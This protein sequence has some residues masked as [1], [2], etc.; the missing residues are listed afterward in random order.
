MRHE[1]FNCPIDM[2]TKAET[3]SLVREAMRVRKPMTHVS[4]N[5]AK[6]VNMRFDP[7]LAEGREEQRFDRN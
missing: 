2:L 6:L 7:I 1:I 5:V 4:L 3:V